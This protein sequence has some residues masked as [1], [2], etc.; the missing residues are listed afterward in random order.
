[1]MLLDHLTADSVQR[2]RKLIFDH[3]ATN[4]RHEDFVDLLCVRG[5]SGEQAA[6][7]KCD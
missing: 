2:D 4:G 6:S 5:Q 1:M 7:L 3:G